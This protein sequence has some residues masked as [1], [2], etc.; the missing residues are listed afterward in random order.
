MFLK[1]ILVIIAAWILSKVIQI[2]QGYSDYRRFSKQG[3][4]FAGDSFSLS[5]DLVN[6]KAIAEK[7]PTTISWHKMFREAFGGVSR[8]PPIIG[9]VFM[10]QINL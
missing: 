9:M 1:F 7:Y 8:L 5:R 2:I 10:G 6:M 3:V 4:K